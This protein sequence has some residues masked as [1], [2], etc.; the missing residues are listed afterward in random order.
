MN[1]LQIL[2][3][4]VASQSILT[5]SNLNIDPQREDTYLQQEQ[6][7]DIQFE[8]DQNLEQEQT[9]DIQFEE[10]Q[11]FKQERELGRI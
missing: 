7:H 10:D 8:E 4:L 9:D 6:T 2:L 3:L 5:A 11:F 1:F